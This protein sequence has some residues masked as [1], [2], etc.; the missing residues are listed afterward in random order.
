MVMVNGFSRVPLPPAKITAIIYL[1]GEDGFGLLV[2]SHSGAD[3]DKN[4]GLRRHVPSYHRGSQG[5]FES[6]SSAI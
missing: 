3:N 5:R 1:N 2:E 4:P 6:A